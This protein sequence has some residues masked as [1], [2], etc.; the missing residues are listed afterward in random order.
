MLATRI[1]SSEQTSIYLSTFPNALAS[2]KVQNHEIS[3]YIPTNSIVALCPA[4][5]LKRNPEVKNS[6]VS[7]RSALSSCKQV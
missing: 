6:L 1:I 5:P 7:E 2:K 4:S 3:I